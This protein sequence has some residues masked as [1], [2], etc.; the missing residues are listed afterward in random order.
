MISLNNIYFYSFRDNVPT[1]LLGAWPINAQ[2]FDGEDAAGPV[3]TLFCDEADAA[4]EGLLTN[5][6]RAHADIQKLVRVF[7]MPETIDL[8]EALALVKKPRYI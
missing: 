2:M 8:D 7:F 3:A 6:Q 5:L 4:K 1:V